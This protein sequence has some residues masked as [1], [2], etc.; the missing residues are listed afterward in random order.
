MYD[1]I[2]S[3]TDLYLRTVTEDDIEEV[4]RMWKPPH[5]LTHEEAL[6]VLRYLEHRR[7]SN[8]PKSIDHICLGVFLKNDNR[9]IIGWCGLDGSTADGKTELF[10]IIDENQRNK[11]Y[12]TQCAIALLRYAFEDMEYDVIHGGCAK[13]NIA[14]Y[15]VM[16]KIGMKQTS[17]AD[18]GGFLFEIDRKSFL[19]LKNIRSNSS[20]RSFPV[21][22]PNQG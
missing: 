12:A 3:T 8:R 4:A 10:Y 5:T 2:L 16:E 13:D 9:K 17:L 6:G 14:S 11:G 1:M 21:N 19:S 22:T 15:M 18:D 20:H 7:S